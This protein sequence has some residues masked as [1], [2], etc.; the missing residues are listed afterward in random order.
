MDDWVLSD[1]LAADSPGPGPFGLNCQN[2]TYGT[3]FCWDT[4]WAISAYCFGI[5]FVF[6]VSQII[7]RHLM[8][9]KRTTKV[10]MNGTLGTYSV[11]RGRTRM[12]PE[13][14][15]MSFLFRG[16]WLVMKGLPGEPWA[17][18]KNPEGTP[19]ESVYGCWK[20]A[21]RE[22]L[23]RFATLMAFSAFTILVIYWAGTA[24]I[25]ETARKGGDDNNSRLS[26][27]LPGGSKKKAPKYTCCQGFYVSLNVWLYLLLIVV[28]VMNF[29]PNDLADQCVPTTISRDLSCGLPEYDPT[30]E[31]ITTCLCVVPNPNYTSSDPDYDACLVNRTR[32]NFFGVNTTYTWYPKHETR[33]DG[34]KKFTI[35]CTNALYLLL[36]MGIIGFGVKVSLALRGINESS[37]YT[38]NANAT[39][40]EGEDDGASKK[41]NRQHIGQNTRCGINVLRCKMISMVVV[42]SACFITRFILFA[43]PYCGGAIFTGLTCDIIRCVS[44]LVS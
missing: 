20:Y 28:S 33:Y 6:G 32:K 38:L 4:P 40:Q 21:L 12:I 29:I 1:D 16:V 37:D 36:V 10:M 5:S 15:T 19:Y 9:N 34:I 27:Y 44:Q 11:K 42:S 24:T 23:N 30:Q 31:N 7:T 14:L 18:G 22:T 8:T 3:P 25:K 2:M 41:K 17:C 43:W 35:L 39:Q 13:L 26:E